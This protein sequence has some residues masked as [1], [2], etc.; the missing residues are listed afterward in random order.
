MRKTWVFSVVAALGLSPAA[1]GF[2]LIFVGD[3]IITVD[4][5]RPTQSPS[6]TA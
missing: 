1:N 3:N 4:P 5:S 6:T 2:D